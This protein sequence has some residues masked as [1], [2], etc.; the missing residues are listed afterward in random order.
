LSEA[1]A[2]L[3]LVVADVNHSAASGCSTVLPRWRSGGDGH[4]PRNRPG[5]LVLPR[6][7]PALGARFNLL[8][9]IRLYFGGFL[10]GR[11]EG[12]AVVLV[13]LGRPILDLLLNRLHAIAGIWVVAEKLRARAALL[14]QLLEELSHRFGV[15]A[16]LPQDDGTYSIRLR[17]ITA[18][19]FHAPHA[20]GDLPAH[21]SNSAPNT[22]DHRT[23]DL[24]QP[25]KNAGA[26]VLLHL[27]GRVLHVH[28]RHFVGNH[29]SQLGFVVGG[30]NGTHID[31][32]WTTWQSKGVDLLL[33]DHVKLIG[34]GVLLRDNPFQLLPQL[35]H[36][37]GHRAGVGQHRHLLVHLSHGFQAQLP[38]LFSGE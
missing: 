4:I 29:P 3:N 24:S 22:S 36:V 32:D 30:S 28:V 9:R 15:V 31:E 35:L 37:L 12:L 13:G 10:L 1:S 2:G 20:A 17:F 25:G 27:L 16:G 11:Y 7:L 23:E 6:P 5:L 34:P 33:L 38:L 8:C 19:I 18:R 14:L 21:T 26:H